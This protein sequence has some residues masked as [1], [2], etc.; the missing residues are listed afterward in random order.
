MVEF[1]EGNHNLAGIADEDFKAAGESSAPTEESDPEINLDKSLDDD[2]ILDEPSVVDK[3]GEK[4]DVYHEKGKVTKEILTIG[5]SKK[6]PRMG[7]LVKVKY[8]AFFYDKTI[9]D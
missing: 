3:L 4:Q 9:F 7:F 1:D 6:K 2:E 5:S 8:T